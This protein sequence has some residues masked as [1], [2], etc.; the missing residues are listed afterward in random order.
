[1]LTQT[2]CPILDEN[3]EPDLNEDSAT[4]LI[5]TCIVDGSTKRLLKR[6]QPGQ[7]AVLSHQDLD[8][9][10]AL[11]LIEKK[12]SAVINARTTFSG[13]YQTDG[14]RRLLEASI[15]ILDLRRF[16][17]LQRFREG[18]TLW[19]T[20][21]KIGSWQGERS[22]SL[23]EVRRLTWD[24]YQQRWR[25]AKANRW[26]E[27]Q[28]FAENTLKHAQHDLHQMFHQT[29][30]I[31]LATVMTGKPVMIVARG[32]HYKK[33]LQMLR[34]FIERAK[35]ILIGVDGGANALLESDLYP[36]LIIGD[37]DSVS[38]NA[39][40]SGAEL[41]VHAYPDRSA[42][43]MRKLEELGLAGHVYPM[44]GTSED[45]ALMLAYEKDAEKI[46]LIGSHSHMIDFFEKGR[47]G[48]G[49]T[50]LV[51]MWVGDRLIDAKGFHHLYHGC[52][53]FPTIQAS[54]TTVI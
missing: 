19:L 33:D 6:I 35:P 44:F 27:F 1:M 51:R 3:S 10:V 13:R 52:Q 26:I 5:G 4:F 16:R 28:K 42:P 53:T 20:D 24:V 45:A 30:N 12:V 43:G 54:T 40:R 34:P 25:Q 37:M 18:M 8:E 38:A 23:A 9:M 7:I 15:P 21:R 29:A 39:L 47:K 17:D 11:E 49:S 31:P 50:W 41:V 22:Y 46:I 32:Q 14:P 36:D 2:L 48:M